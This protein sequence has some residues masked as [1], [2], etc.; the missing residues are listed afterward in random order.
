MIF[1]LEKINFKYV[2]KEP[3]LSEREYFITSDGLTLK[4]QTSVDQEQMF[5]HRVFTLRLN[6]YSISP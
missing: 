3:K 5:F 4:E 2:W 1:C 6:S